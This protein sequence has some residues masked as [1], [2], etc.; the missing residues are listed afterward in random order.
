MLGRLALILSY[1]KTLSC[2]A[3]LKIAM[4]DSPPTPPTTLT[5][6]EH[7]IVYCGDNLYFV[8]IPNIGGT[9]P[10]YHPPPGIA[11]H[12]YVPRAYTFPGTGSSVIAPV[13]DCK[14][15]QREKYS[16][17]CIDS[18]GVAQKL[19]RNCGTTGGKSIIMPR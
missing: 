2:S 7:L 5:W 18:T 8:P 16:L 9:F 14:S 19:P 13:P 1:G 17:I 3:S 11:A 6:R 15:Y 4:G 12:E 10:L